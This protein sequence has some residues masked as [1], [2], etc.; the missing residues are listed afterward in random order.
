MTWL[1]AAGASIKKRFC[2]PSNRRVSA[3]R[4]TWQRAEKKYTSIDPKQQRTMFPRRSCAIKNSFRAPFPRKE[5]KEKKGD[6]PRNPSPEP[7]GARKS[8]WNTILF[9]SKEKEKIE[10]NKPRN[11]SWNKKEGGNHDGSQCH[12]TTET[13]PTTSWDQMEP[14]QMEQKARRLERHSHKP[15][16]EPGNEDGTG[17]QKTRETIPGNLP[18]TTRIEE[19]MTEQNA[20]LCPTTLQCGLLLFPSSS[21]TILAGIQ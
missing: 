17:C 2:C 8:R 19:M 18:E 11:P 15:Y 21:S 13:S 16:P 14:R 7:E 10:G 6:K 4:I 9:P 5:T 12:S 1:K 20:R 3:H